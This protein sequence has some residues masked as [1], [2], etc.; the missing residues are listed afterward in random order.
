MAMQNFLRQ[1]RALGV[2]SA[3][4][5]VEDAKQNQ[6]QDG[7]QFSCHI[8]FVFLAVRSSEANSVSPKLKAHSHETYNDDN[9]VSLAQ[10][11][12]MASLIWPLPVTIRR[13]I[14]IRLGEESVAGN[15][16]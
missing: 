5:G 10:I 16:P 15:D 3:E 2:G 1:R 7:N 12:R 14:T 13:M 9:R 11:A 8:G 4:S 6:R